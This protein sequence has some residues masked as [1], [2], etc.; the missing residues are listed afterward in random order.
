L[1]M[2]NDANHLGYVHGG[3]ILSIADKVA[4]VCACRH[5]GALCVTACVDSVGFRSPI[6]VGQ[7]VSFLASVNHVGNSS[8]EVGIKIVAEDLITREQ[9]HTNSC[10]FTLVALDKKGRPQAVPQLVLTSAE[11]KRR[12]A[13]AKERR[14]FRLNQ[15]GK[16]A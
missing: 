6:K 14:A 9:T 11:D 16:H 15:L 7:L 10:Y 5:A 2:P 4:F 12:N 3:T 1:M 8:M 13:Q